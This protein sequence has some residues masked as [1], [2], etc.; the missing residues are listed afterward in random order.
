MILL[1]EVSKLGKINHTEYK[2]LLTLLNPFAPHVTEEIWT[3]CGF[4][5]KISEVKWPEWNEEK[6]VKDEIEYAIQINNK[7]IERANFSANASNEE[8]ESQVITSEKVNSV[9]NGRQVMKV[10][11]IKNRLVNIIAK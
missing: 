11:V 4:A 3:N 10:I 6:L 7:I 8:I 5:P 9:L 1:N 2:A